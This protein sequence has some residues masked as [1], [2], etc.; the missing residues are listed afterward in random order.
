MQPTKTSRDVAC[1][2][3]CPTR[4]LVWLLKATQ[5]NYPDAKRGFHE[6]QS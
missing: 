5:Q 6:P 1:Y 2:V 4:R 3:S